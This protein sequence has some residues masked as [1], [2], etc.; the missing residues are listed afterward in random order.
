MTLLRTVARPMLASMFVYGGAMSLRNAPAMA[1]TAKPM[2]DKIAGAIRS[3]APGVQLP[4][5]P[6]TLV[7]VNGALHVGFGTAL[8]L[9]R[10]PRLSA[11]VLAGTLVPTTT[12]AHS[13]WSESDPADASGQKIHFFKNMSIIGGLLMAT[14]DPDPHKKILPRRAK[15]KVVEAGGAVQ[16]TLQGTAHQVKRSLPHR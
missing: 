1:E 13:F 14:L 7:R 8:A 10:F 6:V 2:S 5:D 3:V 16:E 12:A 9:G 15:D 4:T 11:L